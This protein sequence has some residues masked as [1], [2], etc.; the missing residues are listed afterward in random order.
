MCVENIHT[1][2]FIKR[3][4]IDSRPQTTLFI[5]VGSENYSGTKIP[6]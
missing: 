4:K 3:M 5:K 2:P 6:R 1:P